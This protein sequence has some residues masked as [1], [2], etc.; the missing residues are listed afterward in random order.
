M[1]AGFLILVLMTLLYSSRIGGKKYP[2]EYVAEKIGPYDVEFYDWAFGKEWDMK[3]PLIK[4]L[5]LWNER[6]PNMILNPNGLIHEDI[7]RMIALWLKER[8][9]KDHLVPPTKDG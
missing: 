5:E 7:D 4:I 8:H 3:M 9:G 6:H 1:I 2:Q